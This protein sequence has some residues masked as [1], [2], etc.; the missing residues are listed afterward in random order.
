[1]FLAWCKKKNPQLYNKMDSKPIR[2][3]LMLIRHNRREDWKS[4]VLPSERVIYFIDM[5]FIGYEILRL[6]NLDSLHNRTSTC[7]NLSCDK[8]GLYSNFV[9]MNMVRLLMRVFAWI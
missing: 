4:K 3:R 8:S 2:E 1:M 5:P 7:L 9:W 6:Y